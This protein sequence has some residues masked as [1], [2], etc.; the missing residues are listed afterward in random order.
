MERRPVATASSFSTRSDAEQFVARVLETRSAEVAAW[1]AAPPGP[2]GHPWKH[3]D[4]DFPKEVT[5]RFIHRGDSDASDASAVR[6]VLRRSDAFPMGY[7]IHNGYPVERAIP[8]SRPF[9]R[10]RSLF[11][12]YF[13]QEWDLDFDDDPDRAVVV[14]LSHLDAEA[15]AEF[16]R[17]LDRMLEAETI[18]QALFRKIGE[19]AFCEFEAVSRPDWIR[20]IRKRL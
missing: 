3:V 13:H 2:G 19:P 20:H 18:D 12:A 9:P 7:R 8:E 1:L 16:A 11:L 5:G 14:F 17:E 6:V 10:T 15:K 4:G